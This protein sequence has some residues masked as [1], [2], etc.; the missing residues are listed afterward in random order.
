MPIPA[1]GSSLHCV[2]YGSVQCIACQQTTLGLG[3]HLLDSPEQLIHD[4][5]P[6]L[7]IK[8]NLQARKKKS[9]T[10]EKCMANWDTTQKR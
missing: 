3:P 4:M 7:T 6:Q 5:K 8:E 1:S 9:S 10:L 2:G